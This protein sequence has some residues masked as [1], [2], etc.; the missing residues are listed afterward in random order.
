[1]HN[2]FNSEVVEI[3]IKILDHTKA[4]N[5]LVNDTTNGLGQFEA[6]SSK[7]T[8]E[9][10]GIYEAENGGSRISNDGW[11]DDR[12]NHAENNPDESRRTE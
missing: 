7:I 3:I 1:M 6:N 12:G 5:L 4:L 8:E 9:L 10:N 2:Q 11:K